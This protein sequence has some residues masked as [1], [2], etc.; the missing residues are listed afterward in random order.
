[1]ASHIKLGPEVRQLKR[2][3][4]CIQDRYSTHRYDGDP[5]YAPDVSSCLAMIFALYAC[6]ISPSSAYLP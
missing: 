4:T 2:M 5:H 1:M 3:V 6:H